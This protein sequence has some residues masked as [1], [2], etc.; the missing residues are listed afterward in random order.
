MAFFRAIFFCL[1]A[2][3][4]VHAQ[5]K[6]PVLKGAV[7]GQEM[8]E[9]K[10]EVFMD[11]IISTLHGA[12]MC[13]S[14]TKDGKTFYYNKKVNDHWAIVMTREVDGMWMPPEPIP[15][16]AEYTDR[17]FTLSPDGSRLYWGSNRP[18][19]KGGSMLGSL[20]IFMSENSS[21]HLW[22]EPVNVGPSINTE[23]GENYPSVAS[24]GNLYFFFRST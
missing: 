13:A 11:G 7:F 2:M 17:D 9:G 20:D 14:L 22:T 23:A 16:I 3:Q 19:R 6:F 4:V 21:D 12:E 8:P 15:F 1:L 24:N 18:R 10:A 5:E